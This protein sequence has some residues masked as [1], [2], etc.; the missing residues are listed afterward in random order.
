MKEEQEI[1]SWEAF[2]EGLHA[3]ATNW[4]TTSKGSWSDEEEEGTSA[5]E[6]CIPNEEV[7]EISIHA[8]GVP[9]TLDL[10]L[11]SLKEY[12]TV[13]GTQWLSMLGPIMGFSKVAHVI[14]GGWKTSGTGG[15]KTLET[16]IM[17]AGRLGKEL[18]KNGEGFVLRINS[19]SLLDLGE[20]DDQITKEEINNELNQLLQDLENV[21]R[22]PR[23]LSQPRP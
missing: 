16:N 22:E 5:I 13:L 11:L 6:S 17:D 12:D 23:E 18:Q 10:Y 15:M 14:C 9:I 4:G 21:F 8:L 20:K 3:R 2:K 1:V 19:L 7:S